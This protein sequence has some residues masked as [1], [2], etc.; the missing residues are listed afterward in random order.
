MFLVRVIIIICCLCSLELG[1]FCL[2][3]GHLGKRFKSFV[4]KL[5]EYVWYTSE[6]TT[7]T[8]YSVMARVQNVEAQKHWRSPVLSK[9][10]AKFL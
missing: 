7:C 5:T 6:I 4:Q 9:W 8:V 3:V 1:T 2:G 10:P